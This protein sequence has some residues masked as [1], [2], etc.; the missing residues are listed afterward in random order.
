MTTGPGQSFP[1]VLRVKTAQDMIV[2]PGTAVTVRIQLN[3]NISDNRGVVVPSS[4]IFALT[5]GQSAIWKINQETMTVV[6]I[7]VQ[8]GELTENGMH[9]T[10]KID[11]QDQFVV[12]DARFLSEGQRIRILNKTYGRQL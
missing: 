3:K 5:D 8:I 2:H 7:P 4:A 12:A 11:I 10:G 1:L 6:S 9:I